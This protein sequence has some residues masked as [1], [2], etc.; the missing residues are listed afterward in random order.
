MTIHSRPS[1]TSDLPITNPG[2]VLQ[3]KCNGDERNVDGRRDN[4]KN[5]DK[6]GILQRKA[7]SDHGVDEVPP[8]VHDV[9]RSSGHP[10]DR[11]YRTF[12][13]PRFGH[14]FSR[15]RIHSDS[16]AAE[17]A[18]AINALAYTFGSHIVFPG[19][20]LQTSSPDGLNL[21]SHELAHVV[22]QKIQPNFSGPLELDSPNSS[23]ETEAD[24]AAS[25]ILKSHTCN[26][27]LRSSSHDCAFISRKEKTSDKVVSKRIEVDLGSQTATAFEGT[28]P[29]RRMSVSTGKAGKSTPNG[30]FKITER[31]KD[32]VSYYGSC[33][34]KKGDRRKV[35]SKKTPCE[36]GETLDRVK[37]PYFQRFNG[38]V[39]FHVGENPGE[40]A[41]AGCVRLTVQDAQFLWKWAAE[42]TPVRVD[43]TYQKKEKDKK[44][45][46][47]KKST[48][49][50]AATTLPSPLEQQLALYDFPAVSTNWIDSIEIEDGEL[51]IAS[52]D[53][54][55]DEQEGE[56]V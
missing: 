38:P 33:V 30:N 10:L 26:S 23:L 22:Q 44:K 31:I 27:P 4:C 51:E 1:Q 7:K 15:V 21:L 52:T 2:P 25:E 28:K 39:G 32:H 42:G 41:S 49:K 8:I 6:F 56:F 14:D 46:G 20:Q 29:V 53:D 47:S 19:S 11:E 50:S 9:L 37:M 45:K 16:K 36:K 18:D 43:G 24:L 34:S 17:S 48:K 54:S 12:F 55:L 40:P 13:E 5:N 3:R 35:N